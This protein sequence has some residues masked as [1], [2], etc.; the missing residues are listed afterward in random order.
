MCIFYSSVLDK[1]QNTRQLNNSYKNEER[2]EKMK[3]NIEL[4]TNDR[5]N[6][7]E[8]C[9]SDTEELFNGRGRKRGRG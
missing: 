1:E 5:M 4:I 8:E 3:K 6:M 2:K 9:C 7:R